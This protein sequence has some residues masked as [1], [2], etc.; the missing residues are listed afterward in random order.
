MN[1]EEANRLSDL[2]HGVRWEPWYIRLGRYVALFSFVELKTHELANALAGSSSADNRRTSSM[3]VSA[4]LGAIRGRADADT[5]GDGLAEY[6]SR[7]V[8]R[9]A[10]A[11][12][13]R[14]DLVHG[15]H[16]L[17]L[18]SGQ[19]VRRAVSEDLSVE[20]WR[21]GAWSK[22]RLDEAYQRLRA[23]DSD[24]ATARV[25][26]ESRWPRPPEG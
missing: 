11:N 4:L 24:L 23:I 25:A 14:N 21:G 8:V 6:I 3:P 22:E 16:Y 18:G 19:R 9:L 15:L 17:S 20:E 12:D 1:E 2:W 5:L 26:V 10:N 7:L 13:E